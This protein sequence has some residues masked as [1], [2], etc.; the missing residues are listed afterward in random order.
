MAA[1][2]SSHLLAAVTQSTQHAHIFHATMLDLPNVGSRLHGHTIDSVSTRNSYMHLSYINFILTL[3]VV[4][5]QS[6][7]RITWY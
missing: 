7:A 2:G 1:L 4:N 5:A 6:F 3:N